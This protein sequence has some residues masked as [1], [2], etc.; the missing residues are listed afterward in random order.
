MYN[1]IM[2]TSYL[3][4]LASLNFFL[5][6]LL[7]NA[8]GEIF[9]KSSVAP[10]AGPHRQLV[11]RPGRAPWM[12]PVPLQ[13]SAR[14]RPPSGTC[15]LQKTLPLHHQ[16]SSVSIYRGCPSPQHTFQLVGVVIITSWM[17]LGWLIM[18]G[19]QFL[20]ISY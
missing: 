19:I 13:A 18:C 4:I 12:G 20:R 3:A 2:Q 7:Q 17:W 6:N 16:V 10:V 14:R 8:C 15:I 1:L 9:I 11:A 5:G